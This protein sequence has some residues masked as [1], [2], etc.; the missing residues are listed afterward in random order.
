MK[1]FTLL[2]LVFFISITQEKLFKKTYRIKGK[3]KS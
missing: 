2:F 1:I 3:L